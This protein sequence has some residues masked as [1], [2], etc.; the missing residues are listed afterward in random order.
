MMTLIT[1]VGLGQGNF[2]LD[3]DP[4]P[5]KRGTAPT[6][7]FSAHVYDCQTAGCI[8]IPLGAGESLGPGYIVLEGDPAPPP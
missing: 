7:Y 3:G 8:R 2:V 5:E 6:A 4:A 1:E